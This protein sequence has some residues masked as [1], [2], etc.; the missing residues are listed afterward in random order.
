[1]IFYEYFYFI[2]RRWLKRSII[3]AFFYASIMVFALHAYSSYN[4]FIATDDDRHYLFNMFSIPRERW[5]Y[6]YHM[7]DDMIYLRA[8]ISTV[9]GDH[10]WIA[11]V[12]FDVLF[13]A[14]GLCCWSVVGF[15]D[16]EG[17]IQCSFF[18]WLD[19][20]RD[21]VGHVFIQGHEEAH[22]EDIKKV[23]CLPNPGTSWKKRSAIERR[24]S[25]RHRLENRPEP[26]VTQQYFEWV[27]YLDGR[28]G[29]G[30]K[31][32]ARRRTRSPAGDAL[33][34]ARN[35][36][37]RRSSRSQPLERG[38]LSSN[39]LDDPDH[40]GDEEIITTTVAPTTEPAMGETEAAALT[41]GLFAIGGLGVAS[42]AVFGAEEVF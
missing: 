2:K 7:R 5:R 9:L 13:S 4:A 38:F 27:D 20:T 29:R 23:G 3:N 31:S 36:A 1:M 11:S 10:H 33:S 17:M 8:S 12:A 21:P 41:W 19:E 32:R 34:R 25:D 24:P 35:N 14:I 6:Y 37:K 40:S 39:I 42:N 18:P 26:E 30:A 15:V 22:Y 16:V 28:P